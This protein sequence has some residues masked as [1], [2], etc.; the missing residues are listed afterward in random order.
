[1]PEG[2]EVRVIAECL[3]DLLRGTELQDICYDED[4]KYENKPI[5]NFDR[6]LDLLP[7]NIEG[8]TAKGKL[9]IFVLEGDNYITS[10]IGFGRWIKKRE[11][12]SNFWLEYDE[13]YIYF[14]DQRHFGLINVYFGLDQLLDEKL[15][16]VGPDFLASIEGFM[17]VKIS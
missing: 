4:S 11:E 1:M 10:N 12:H 2:P 3:D 16:N 15:V 13:K 9:I 17:L 14:D 5:P 6:F 8:V 7:L